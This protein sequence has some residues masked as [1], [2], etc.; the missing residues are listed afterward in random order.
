MLPVRFGDH[1]QANKRA[2][3]QETRPH[4]E[5]RSVEQKSPPRRRSSE[6]AAVFELVVRI[7]EIPSGV[8]KDDCRCI[9]TEDRQAKVLV[10]LPSEQRAHDKWRQ[11]G[12][13]CPRLQ[14][15]GETC[16]GWTHIT[17]AVSSHDH[18]AVNIRDSLTA[19]AVMSTFCLQSGLLRW[20]T[21]DWHHARAWWHCKARAW[22]VTIR[23]QH[24]GGVGELQTAGVSP[25]DKISIWSEGHYSF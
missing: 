12:G 21:D 18:S 7:D 6:E 13:E 3:R 2:E 22:F 14:S 4:G 17:S 19:V 1:Q 5:A 25:E 9:K 8:C 15:F 20:M 24:G 23:R 10:E 16:F 11:R